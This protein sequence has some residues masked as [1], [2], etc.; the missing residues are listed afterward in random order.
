[1]KIFPKFL[2]GMLVFVISDNLEAQVYLTQGQALKLAFPGS[3]ITVERK[4]LFLTDEQVKE[5]QRL[6]K[7]KVESKIVTYYAG[8]SAKGVEGYVF[9]ETNIVRTMP[10]TFMIVV[11]P[12]SS[13][14]FVEMLAFYEP[15]DYLPTKRWFELFGEKELNK[16]LW[17]KR[18][19]ANVSGATLSSNAITAGV[20]R[21]LAT[22][23]VAVVKERK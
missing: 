19:I 20:R 12:D 3:T 17:V 15:P 5:I 14:R 6:A 18:G 9:F 23:E 11:N 13:V 22:F 7:T 4:T 8:L 1:L 16:D 2:L 21:A 10:E